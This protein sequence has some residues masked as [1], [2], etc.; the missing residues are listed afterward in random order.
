MTAIG[1]EE[2]SFVVNF[3]PA[4]LSIKNSARFTLASKLFLSIKI[5]NALMV[6]I[7]HW[8]SLTKGW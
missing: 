4:S 5:I 8:G 1:K 6:Y 2:L 3:R 7:R